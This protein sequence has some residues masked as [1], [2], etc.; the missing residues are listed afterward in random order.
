MKQFIADGEAL[1][2]TAQ[3]FFTGKAHSW[4]N[5]IHDPRYLELGVQSVGFTHGAA[6]Q[7]GNDTNQWNPLDQ[8]N[9][10]VDYDSQLYA[11]AD[12][13]G[14]NW[15]PSID[16]AGVV[17]FTTTNTAEASFVA[18]DAW[19]ASRGPG[20][21]YVAIWTNTN[22]S[23]H[24]VGGSA[25]SC[26]GA[27]TKNDWPPGAVIPGSPTDVD[28]YLANL[29][30]KDDW[31]QTIMARGYFTASADNVICYGNDNGTANPMSLSTTSEVPSGK[32]KNSVFHAG[33]Y[34]GLVCAGRG[35][36]SGVAMGFDQLMSMADFGPT[37]LASYGMALREPGTSRS[38]WACMT[39]ANGETYTACSVSRDHIDHYLYKRAVGNESH[40]GFPNAQT[41]ALGLWLDLRIGV[42]YPHGGQLWLLTEEYDET[43]MQT[44]SPYR[45]SELFFE[46]G[47]LGGGVEQY[48]GG[49]SNLGASN[50]EAGCELPQT[51][52][53]AIEW[54]D[55]PQQYQ[56]DALAVGRAFLDQQGIAPLVTLGGGSF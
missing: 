2:L 10:Y 23:P 46:L 38:F 19:M 49:S 9:L 29:K 33:T 35:I 55:P 26:E 21:Y 24:N 30:H 14:H 12:C 39:G 50:F 47:S 52:P 8:P 17:T 44:I 31:L 36:T 4:Q 42:T 43:D 48:G 1:G 15:T 41:D 6:V 25:G 11:W 18:A 13:G 16:F 3:A 56:L 28:V 53:G 7:L 22:H 5:R 32:S 45:C 54:T 40:H 20:V 34:S 27:E 37:V 51:D